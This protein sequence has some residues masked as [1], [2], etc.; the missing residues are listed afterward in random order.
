VLLKAQ[1]EAYARPDVRRKLG[2]SERQLRA[3]ER[4]GLVAPAESYSFS[5]LIALKTLI[6][7]RENRIGTRQIGR[8]LESLRRKLPRIKQPLAEL[9]IVSDGR[10]IAVKMPGE[11]MEAIS[12]QML[13]DFETADLGSVKTFP[14]R[15]PA[16]PA[17]LLKEAEAWFQKGLTLEEQGAPVEEAVT[18]YRK[19]VELNPSAAG[20]LVNLGT[21]HYRQRRFAEAE[22]YYRD[23]ISADP[24]YPLAEFNLG[25]LYDEQSRLAEALEHYRRALQL[26]PHYADAHFNLALLSERTGD[27]LRAVHHWK[28]YLKLDSSGQWAEIARRQLDRLREAALIH[29]R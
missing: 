5:D 26:N 15:A 9:R 8:A 10:T 7:L 13:F 12:G 2:V 18:A 11:K 24:G 16:N 22:K 20:A 21:I 25:N 3:W 14:D 27:P 1:P 29:S 6:K 17:L 19:A 4:L 23:A 28:A